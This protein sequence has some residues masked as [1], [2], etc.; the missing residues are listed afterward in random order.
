MPGESK[1][2]RLITLN[3]NDFQIRKSLSPPP[4]GESLT[5][6]L[7]G[8]SGVEGGF[9]SSQR[10]RSLCFLFV[11]PPGGVLCLPGRIWREKNNPQRTDLRGVVS[12]I[13]QKQS[14]EISSANIGKFPDY[15]QRVPGISFLWWFLGDFRHFSSP[16]G[17]FPCPI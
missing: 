14:K 11:I 6:L 1:S 10:E 13:P 2:F 16:G 17:G 5:Y 12:K 9:P 7:R 3:R 8:E 15:S 4:E